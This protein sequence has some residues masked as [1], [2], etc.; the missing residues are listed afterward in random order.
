MAEPNNTQAT[1][2]NDAPTYEGINDRLKQ[3]VTLVDDPDIPLDDALDLFEEAVS[4]GM[5]ASS[6]LEQG[7]AEQKAADAASNDAA[8]AALNDASGNDVAND[9]V[10]GE[11][12]PIADSGASERGQ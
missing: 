11:H 10:D 4:L 2:S 3:I 6:L 1:A 5:Q 7:I 8:D 12:E 9:A